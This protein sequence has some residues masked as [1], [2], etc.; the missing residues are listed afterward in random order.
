MRSRALKLL[1][2]LLAAAGGVVAWQ[3]RHETPPL[4]PAEPFMDPAP[5]S[6]GS[7]ATPVRPTPSAGTAPVGAT[8]AA[9]SAVRAD[10]APGSEAVEEVDTAELPTAASAEAVEGGIAADAGRVAAD[11]APDAGDALPT[12]PHGPFTT[13]PDGP[14][15][16]LKQIAGIGPAIERALNA[17]GITTFAQLAGLSDDD[18]DALQKRL[19]QLPGR[20]R[21][22]DWVGQAARLAA[23]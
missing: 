13:A 19:P 21:R 1:L 5:V 17:Q 7:V 9:A 15:D 4:P 8:G 22:D 6:A 12:P 2:F 20:I 3:R 16:D 10:E 11:R 18:V 23:G 14:A